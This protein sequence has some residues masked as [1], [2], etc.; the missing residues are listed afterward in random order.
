[1]SGSPAGIPEKVMPHVS[2]LYL[3][4]ATWEDIESGHSHGRRATD[5]FPAIKQGAWHEIAVKR[6]VICEDAQV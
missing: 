2:F 6:S 4:G 1:M 5:N 3:S